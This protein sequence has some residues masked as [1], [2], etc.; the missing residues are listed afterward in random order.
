M[1]RDMPFD[2]LELEP[3]ELTA[4]FAPILR[5][6]RVSKMYFP[7]FMDAPVVAG[8]TVVDDDITIIDEEKGARQYEF[9][10]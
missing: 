6:G 2:R 10:A 7:V 9:D 3:N 8:A 4:T 1:P 5:E